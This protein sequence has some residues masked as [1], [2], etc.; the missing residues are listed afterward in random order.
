MP[1]WPKD[2]IYV[3]LISTNGWVQ[4]WTVQFIL[5]HITLFSMIIM[6]NNTLHCAVIR[7]VVLF[8]SVCVCLC[9]CVCVGRCGVFWRENPDMYSLA[10]VLQF[11]PLKLKFFFGAYKIWSRVEHMKMCILSLAETELVSSL[12]PSV[13][14]AG[15]QKGLVTPQWVGSCWAVLPQHQGCPSSTPAH[16]QPGAGQDLRRGH[17][18]DSWPQLTT[19]IPYPYDICPAINVRK[20]E[21]RGVFVT[22]L[23]LYLCSSEKHYLY[24]SPA[25]WQWLD[26]AADRK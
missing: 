3:I 14:G 25:S 15:S 7:Q 2:F 20:E 8:F 1:S 11:V 5:E 12:Q 26:I 23:L 19:G 9:V 22:V 13:L 4:H 6:C 21:T 16:Q 17:S 18:Q 24:R 10:I